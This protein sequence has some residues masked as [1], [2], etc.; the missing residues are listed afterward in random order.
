M[1]TFP[2]GAH[3][4]SP[5]RG[6]NKL[7]IPKYPCDS[8]HTHPDSNKRRIENKSRLLYFDYFHVDGVA[9]SGEWVVSESARLGGTCLR[10]FLLLCTYFAMSPTS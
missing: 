5:M 1:I 6:L 7:T 3:H 9:R 2:I 8:G 4:K 10:L